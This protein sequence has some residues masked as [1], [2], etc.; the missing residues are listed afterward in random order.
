MKTLFSVSAFALVLTSCTSHPSN[1]GGSGGAPST[2]SVS[3]EVVSASAQ[4][5]TSVVP[6]TSSSAAVPAPSGSTAHVDSCFLYDE[7]E[8]ACYGPTNCM[9]CEDQYNDAGFSVRSSGTCC[10]H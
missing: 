7:V 5:A 2:S 3:P 9:C 1:V 8:Q 10:S 4:P 6:S